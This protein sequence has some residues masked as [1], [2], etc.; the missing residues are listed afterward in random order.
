MRATCCWLPASHIHSG[1]L[2]AF[3]S[4]RLE[5]IDIRKTGV[6]AADAKL[7]DPDERVLLALLNG[8]PPTEKMR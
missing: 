5:R 4:G 3:T 7:L 1:V 2:D 8:G 6:S